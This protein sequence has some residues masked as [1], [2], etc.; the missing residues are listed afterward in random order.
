MKKK[1]YFTV[2]KEVYGDGETLNGNKTI[3]VYQIIN[4]EP[5]RFFDVECF[6]E[7]SSQEEIQNYL[8]DNGYGDEEFELILL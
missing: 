6:N 2:E 4:N 5:K 3:T 7:D 8:D 1:L